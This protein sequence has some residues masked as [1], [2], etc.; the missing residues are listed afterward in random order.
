LWLRVDFITA[1]RECALVMPV[2]LDQVPA[3]ASRPVRP[4]KGWWFAGLPLFLLLLGVG[5]VFLFGAQLLRQ[6]PIG[7]LGLAVGIP[8]FGW[9]LLG[10]GRALLYLGQQ[11]VADGWDMAREEDLAHKL[12]RGR[13]VLR[14]LAANHHWIAGSTEEAPGLRLQRVLT[15]VLADLVQVLEQVPGNTPLAV[16]FETESALPEAVSRQAWRQAWSLCGIRQSVV[17]V[18]SGGLDAL[19]YW[20]DH[21]IA[22]QALLLVVTIQF[23]PAQPEGKAEVATGTLFAN[24][25]AHQALPY[26]ACLH[27]PEQAREANDDALLYAA[28]QALEWAPLDAQPVEQIWRVGVDTEGGA[29]L[30][31]VLDKVPIPAMHKKRFNDLDTSQGNPGRASPWLAIAL[32]T[33]A[34]ECGVGSQFIFSGDGNGAHGLWCMVLTPMESF[35]K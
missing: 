28:R 35:S 21:R 13:R 27:R 14:V 11:Q 34:I 25:R 16:L 17:P 7:F 9:C 32:A 3:Q 33:Q 29:Q 8:L 1:C 6:N 18:Q 19:D 10:F 24:S 5:G 23:M 30:L 20:L 2:R 22:D 26:K 15:Q 12:R 31:A 4:G